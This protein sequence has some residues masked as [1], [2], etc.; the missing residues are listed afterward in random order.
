MEISIFPCDLK[1][2]RASY[3]LLCKSEMINLWICSTRLSSLWG[4]EQVLSKPCSVR[5]TTYRAEQDSKL[6]LTQGA[7]QAQRCPETT[8]C[9][10]LRWNARI[11]H[12]S[13][14]QKH[15]HPQ[16]WCL[17][18]GGWQSRSILGRHGIL[19]KYHSIYVNLNLVIHKTQIRI[20]TS[21]NEILHLKSLG[22]GPAH[23][24]SPS[25]SLGRL[26]WHL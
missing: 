8:V 26:F 22:Q 10:E 21:S 9:S 4:K 13:P 19:G 24:R 20:L 16:F 1:E 5:Q 6:W 25:P 18:N 7:P 17:I 15:Q 12:G 23:N 3:H 2:P 11:Q 14:R